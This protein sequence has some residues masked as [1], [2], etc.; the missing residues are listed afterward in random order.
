MLV[1][2]AEQACVMA[3]WKMTKGQEPPSSVN[4]FYYFMMEIFP[5]KEGVSMSS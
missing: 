4:H 2:G 3:E 1:C 5:H